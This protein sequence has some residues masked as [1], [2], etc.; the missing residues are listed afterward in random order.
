MGA[1]DDEDLGFLA[2]LQTAELV[3]DEVDLVGD[4]PRGNRAHGR[5][6]FGSEEGASSVLLRSDPAVAGPSQSR[7][8]AALRRKAGDAKEDADGEDV[9]VTSSSRLDGSH[10]VVAP[11]GPVN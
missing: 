11:G 6:P 5:L 8:T 9:H 7:R 10:S 1:L 4:Q 2:G 3:L